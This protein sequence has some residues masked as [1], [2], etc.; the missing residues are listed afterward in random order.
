MR[1]LR[2]SSYFRAIHFLASRVQK[3]DNRLPRIG[4]TNTRIDR[5]VDNLLSLPVATREIVAAT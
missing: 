4:A 1:V 3:D 2:K 5:V